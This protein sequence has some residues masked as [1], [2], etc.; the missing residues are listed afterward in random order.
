[1]RRANESLDLL[2]IVGTGGELSAGRGATASDRPAIGNDHG[3]FDR[4]VTR[5]AFSVVRGATP[6]ETP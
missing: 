2:A 4:D 1:M 3:S 6:G 5:C